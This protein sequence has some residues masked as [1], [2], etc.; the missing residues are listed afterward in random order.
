MATPEFITHKPRL[1]VELLRIIIAHVI[2]E[3][4]DDLIAGPLALPA[5]DI[6]AFVNDT[7]DPNA[8]AVAAAMNLPTQTTGGYGYAEA[9][10]ETD[11]PQTTHPRVELSPHVDVGM[12]DEPNPI[13]SLLQANMQLRATTLHLL[14]QALGVS[15][16]KEGIQRLSVKPWTRIQPIRHLY[17]NALLFPALHR[18]YDM[19]NTMRSSG[20]IT[21]YMMLSVNGAQLQIAKRQLEDATRTTFTIQKVMSQGLLD[22]LLTTA[23]GPSMI[24]DDIL[25]MRV[26]QRVGAWV[27]KTLNFVA[28]QGCMNTITAMVGLI[29]VAEGVIDECEEE[30]PGVNLG[31]ATVIL[32]EAYS[33][34]YDV[35][36]LFVALVETVT[37][38]FPDR[39]AHFATAD[40]VRTTLEAFRTVT[41]HTGRAGLDFTPCHT[42]A[43]AATDWLLS[44]YPEHSP[45][46]DA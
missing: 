14:S 3:Y 30:V 17:A 29:G 25:R 27:S 7:N 15:V 20:L 33:A 44:S 26:K 1:P 42:A 34:L 32:E 39:V 40:E 36:K 22:S 24:R 5:V 43:K 6:H 2:G 8:G 10:A 37:S 11:A 35:L 18:D 28:F 31:A 9:D 41:E 19:H 38:F 4:L 23:M 45:R 21:S 13:V 12:E 16:V 46:H